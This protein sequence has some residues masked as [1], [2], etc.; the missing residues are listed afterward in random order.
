M[1][2]GV[3]CTVH[4][5]CFQLPSACV[6]LH[7][8]IMIYSY[9]CFQTQGILSRTSL[10]LLPFQAYK[11]IVNKRLYFTL[12]AILCLIYKYDASSDR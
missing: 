1:F 6:C 5:T 12:A 7:N 11:C 8:Y 4:N 9:Q 3:Y 2:V 10:N